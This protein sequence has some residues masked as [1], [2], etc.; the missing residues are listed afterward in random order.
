MR[1][2]GPLQFGQLVRV[3]TGAQTVELSAAVQQRRIGV[4]VGERRIAR[5]QTV[6]ALHI[7]R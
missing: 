5:M 4:V 6:E 2:F 1:L 3:Q 7:G